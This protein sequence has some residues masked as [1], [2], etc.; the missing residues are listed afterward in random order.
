MSIDPIQC[1]GNPWEQDWLRRN[2]GTWGDYPQ[3]WEAQRAIITDY[4]ARLG[5][6][7]LAARRDWWDRPVCEACSCPAGYTLYLLVPDE[8]VAD[9]VAQE[10]EVV[11]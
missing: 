9:I 6:R 5:I 8:D 3:E 4:Y 11:P 1:L 7:V 10:F 2:N